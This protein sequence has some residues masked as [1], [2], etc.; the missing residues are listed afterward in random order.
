[1]LGPAYH[2]THQAEA[3]STGTAFRRAIS[4]ITDTIADEWL[5]QAGELGDDDLSRFTIRHWL[6]VCI[7]H[8]DDLH[9]VIEVEGSRIL[10]AFPGHRPDF[11]RGVNVERTHPE[12]FVTELAAPVCKGHSAAIH[13]PGL[14]IDHLR[15]EDC[16]REVLQRHRVGA[17]HVRLHPP[18]E[19]DLMLVRIEAGELVQVR[20][21]AEPA[22]EGYRPLFRNGPP[23]SDVHLPIPPAAAERYEQP[24][25]DRGDLCLIPIG[26]PD[27]VR[28]TGGSR[29]HDFKSPGAIQFGLSGE[30]LLQDGLG[31]EWQAVQNRFLFKVI[32]RDARPGEGGAIIRNVPRPRREPA[33]SADAELRQ[34]LRRSPLLGP[35]AA[36]SDVQVPQ[37]GY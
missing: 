22:E 20:E 36:C 25:P 8:L 11:D 19:R 33:E 3:A 34:L 37:I 26:P 16:L 35:A 30:L 10:G 23:T 15:L 2:R 4:Q 13:D 28:L 9:V 21:N 17:D 7:D 5:S 18:E 6:S 27:P 1:V 12:G 29:G 32:G 31:E 14:D 24:I